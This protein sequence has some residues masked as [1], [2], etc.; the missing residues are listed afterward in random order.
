[1]LSTLALVASSR[2]DGNTGKVVAKIAEEL[3]IEVVDLTTIRMSAY[4]YEH[5]N[6]GDDFEPLME[7]VLRHEQIIFASPVY[8]YAVTPPMKV[9]FDRLNDFLELAELRPKGKL[10][11]GLGAYVVATSGNNEIS[12]AY[13]SMLTESFAYLA[14][15]YRGFL[16]INCDG[17]YSP[18]RSTA[19]I[20]DFVA[21]VRHAK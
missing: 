18:E 20:Q 14:M 9:F 8:W 7:K 11:R 6:R 3:R 19:E 1:M 10:L 15:T 5:K 21:L 4:D 17:G 12:P 16:H 2:P 13:L